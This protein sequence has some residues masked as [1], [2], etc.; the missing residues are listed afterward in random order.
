MQETIVKDIDGNSY[1]IVRI[2]DQIWL[3]ENLKVTHFN[4]GD[5]IPNT[6]GDWI[7]LST[8][9]Y[10]DYDNNPSNSVTF[11]RLY[12]WYTVDDNR[13]VCPE[14][15]HVPTD[16]EFKRLEMYL[17]MSESKETIVEKPSDSEGWRGTNEGSKLAGNAEL[18]NS[19]KLENDAEFGTSDF[20]GLPGGHRYY[21]SGNYSSMGRSGYF[22]SSSER[23]SSNAMFRELDYFVSN[24]N[25][26]YN[27]KRSGFSIRCVGG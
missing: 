22:W 16:D 8:G 18:W 11:G 3:A 2:G 7:S 21:H 26:G 27:D 25:R 1:N 24:V 12:N 4:N 17:G 20:N 9:A 6:T 13:G 15:F 14:G 10:C 5:E 19:G 23:N